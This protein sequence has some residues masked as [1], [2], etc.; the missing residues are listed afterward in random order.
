M[1]IGV[2]AF[3]V[4]VITP[5]IISSVSN[6]CCSFWCPLHFHF[7]VFF[8]V[9]F[10]SCWGLPSSFYFIPFW[11]ALFVYHCSDLLW[12]CAL[13]FVIGYNNVGFTKQLVG[14]VNIVE[15]TGSSILLLLKRRLWFFVLPFYLVFMDAS[16]IFSPETHIFS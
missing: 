13:I 5:Q 8:W 3:F 4:Y 10:K 9:D 14:Q 15:C 2:V 11:L 6:V 7:L 16:F 1:L 12:T